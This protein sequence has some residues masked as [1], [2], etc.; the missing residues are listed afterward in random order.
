MPPNV[1][2]ANTI[3]SLC[4]EPALFRCVDCGPW[5]SYCKHCCITQHSQCCFLHVPEK[6]ENGRF[7]PVMLMNIEM[8]LDHCCLTEF[9]DK[10]T[11]VSLNGLLIQIWT[12]VNCV[13]LP[14]VHVAPGYHYGVVISFCRCKSKVERLVDLHL[15]PATPQSPRVAF[16]MRLLDVVHAAML[17]CHVSIH[18]A[19]GMLQSLSRL[20]IVS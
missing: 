19:C 18:H 11:I 12:C 14:Y 3:C 6:W 5:M 8:S 7:V 17:E 4:T 1:F 9:K 16:T 13:Q 2:D 10:I 15:W 20:K